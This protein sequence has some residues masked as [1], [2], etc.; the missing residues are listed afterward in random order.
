MGIVWISASAGSAAMRALICA[1]TAPDTTLSASSTTI[2]SYRPPQRR[3]KSAML[4]AL[5]P[6]LSVRRR[7]QTGTGDTSRKALTASV[8]S[9]STAGSRLSDSTKIS[10]RSASPSAAS[11][12]ASAPSRP[13]L[14]AASS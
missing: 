10:A 11:S 4:P 3:T 12:S 8:S 13:M 6:A 5:R 2:W 14:P 9:A 1:M 7:Y